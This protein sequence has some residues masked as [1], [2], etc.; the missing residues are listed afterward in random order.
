MQTLKELT[1]CGSGWAERRARQ[2]LDL[3]AAYQSKDITQDEYQELLQDLVRTDQ[4]E[5]EADDMAI[6]A[7]LVTCVYAL[8]KIV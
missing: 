1:T 2:A 8:S 3:Q 4:L 7:A 5:N 6:K